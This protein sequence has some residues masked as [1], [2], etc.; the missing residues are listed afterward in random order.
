MSDLQASAWAALLAVAA[1]ISKD[2]LITEGKNCPGFDEKSQ[3]CSQQGSSNF[4]AP[5]GARDVGH[6]R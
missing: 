3:F 1:I 2:I 6:M 4:G 5:M